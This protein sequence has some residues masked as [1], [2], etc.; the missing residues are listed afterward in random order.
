MK[1]KLTERQKINEFIGKALE[2]FLTNRASKSLDKFMKTD[3]ALRKKINTMNDKAL[4]V[5]DHLEK[6]KQ[7][8]AK[9]R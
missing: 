2:R 6:V 5:L 1:N 3:P 7:G 4:D 9:L 8:K